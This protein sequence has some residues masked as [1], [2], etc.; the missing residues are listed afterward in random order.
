M[1]RLVADLLELSRLESG[2]VTPRLL[3]TDLAA[4]GQ[5]AVD[6]L[7]SRAEAKVL[8]VTLDIPSG[9]PPVLADGDMLRQ[10]LANLLDNAIK[11]TPSGGGVTLS[12]RERGSQVAVTV[13][14]TG[15]GIAP[16]HLPH[17]FE[18]FYKGDQPRTGP[19]TGL[20]LAIVKHIVQAHGGEIGVESEEGRGSSF[21]FTLRAARA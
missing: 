11:F 3:A 19:S 17:I 16:Q 13:A 15:I 9:L 8:R 5:E 1:T 12:A 18:R 6:S 14:D 2:Q 7:L 21:T 4:L 10:V 20:G